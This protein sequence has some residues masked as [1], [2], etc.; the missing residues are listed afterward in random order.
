MSSLCSCITADSVSC[1][2]SYSYHVVGDRTNISC[3]SA[4]QMR[5]VIDISCTTIRNPS[6][7]GSSRSEQM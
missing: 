6:Y 7:K 1:T 2:I 3:T 5:V 4:V